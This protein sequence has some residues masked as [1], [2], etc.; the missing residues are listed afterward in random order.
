MPKKNNTKHA[1]T[2]TSNG[3]IQTFWKAAGCPSGRLCFKVVSIP[4]F[5]LLLVGSW[6]L[7]SIGAE[8]QTSR[9]PRVRDLQEQRLDTL[10]NL[11]KITS[12]HYKNGLAS[13][14]EMWSAT[15]AKD[16]AELDLCTSNADRIAILKRIVAEAKELEEQDAKLV[17][18]KLSSRTILLRATAD[19]LGQEIRLEDAK[20]Q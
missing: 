7:H 17:T 6:L 3:R 14:D 2:E 5:G 16:E 8:A 9:G 4:A 1:D 11:V 10:R 15:R 20:T 18:N 12:E 19:R 13:S